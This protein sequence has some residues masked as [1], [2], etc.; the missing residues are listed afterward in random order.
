M[1]AVPTTELP[2]Q[3]HPAADPSVERFVRKPAVSDDGQLA[4]AK[5]GMEPRARWVT[6]AVVC[7]LLGGLAIVVSRNALPWRRPPAATGSSEQPSLV[8]TSTARS[9]TPI[10]DPAR[11]SETHT[12]P[13]PPAPPDVRP[14]ARPPT[15]VHAVPLATPSGEPDQ[16]TSETRRRPPK[17]KR[18]LKLPVPG[19]APPQTMPELE[20][21]PDG[22]PILPLDFGEDSP[23]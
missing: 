10:P 15:I 7:A 3:A 19:A 4:V 17:K 23:K 8:G 11:A 2:P 9:P 12:E 22:S 14:G 13:V 20:R 5:R 1:V 6:A 18:R 16:A 21:A